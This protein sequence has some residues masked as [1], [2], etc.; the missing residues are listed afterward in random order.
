MRPAPSRARDPGSGA[1]SPC[2]VK[3]TPEAEVKV[4]PTG[5]IRPACAVLNASASP[6]TAL[7][8]RTIVN[9]NDESEASIPMGN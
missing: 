8:F 9:E 7:T 5:R 4:S 2:C 3:K 1:D 6:S